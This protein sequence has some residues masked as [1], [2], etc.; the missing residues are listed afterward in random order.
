MDAA[1][2]DHFSTHSADYASFRP[3]YPP[4][5]ADYLAS[6]TPRHDLA[7]DCGCGNGQL[8]VL[9]ADRFTKV[10]ATDASAQQI[11]QAQRHARVAYRQARA[12]TTGLADQSADLITVAQAAHWF[13]LDAF[14][15]EVRR[16]LRP[17]GAIVLITYG[18]TETDREIRR[19]VGHFYKDVI[20]PYWPPERRHVEDG[21]RTLPFPFREE[22]APPLA[23]EREWTADDLVGYVSTWSASINAVAALGRAPLDDFAAD[24]RAVWG[25]PEAKRK[26]RWP[27]S[28]RVGRL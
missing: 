4:A 22:E 2:K 1:F 9:L 28:L 18:V 26:I 13:D 20:G 7:L 12:E 5:L 17:G 24:L 16:M 27:L 6:L 15:A 23:I 21:Y 19:C 25:A 3:T 14:Y 10:V 11:A 8:S